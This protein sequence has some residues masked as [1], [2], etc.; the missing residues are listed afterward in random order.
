MTTFVQMLI[1]ALLAVTA[2]NILFNGGVGFSHVLRAARRPKTLGVYSLFVTLFSLLSS[3]G[4]LW[5]STQMASSVFR[6]V[7]FPSVVAFCAVLEYVLAAMVLKMLFLP[8]YKRYGQVLAPAAINTVVLS[9]PFAV[10]RF[11]L[12]LSSAAGYALGTGIAFYF[13]AGI[14][15]H[16]MPGLKNDAMP[17]AFRG[18]PAMLLYIGILSMAFAGLTGAKLF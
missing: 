16:A 13:A 18:L 17:K 8:F 12:S 11:S 9:I 7:L 14:L 15:A 1:A 4:G 5:I 2:E 10:N 3:V 6:P